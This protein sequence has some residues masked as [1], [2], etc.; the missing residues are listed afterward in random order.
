MRIY[1]LYKTKRHPISW[2]PTNYKIRF[3]EAEMPTSAP[4]WTWT[5]N[6]AI[7]KGRK[8]LPGTGKHPSQG[9][10]MF[11]QRCPRKILTSPLKPSPM[12]IGLTSL[13]LTL[14]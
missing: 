8:T 7:P 5:F 14:F 6:V 10:D 11:L 9:I 13:C 3:Y 2:V 12:S 1:I 4:F